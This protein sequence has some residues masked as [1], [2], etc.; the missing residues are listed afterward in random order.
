M[1]MPAYRYH[2]DYKPENIFCPVDSEETICGVAHIELYSSWY[3]IDDD[4]NPSDFVFSL[5]NDMT[6]NPTCEHPEELGNELFQLLLN[7]T[8]TLRN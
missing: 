4:S 7:R 2:K 5:N 8:R 6:Y 3:F 1:A